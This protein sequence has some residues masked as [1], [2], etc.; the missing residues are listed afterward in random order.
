MA[1]GGRLRDNLAGYAPELKQLQA[2]AFDVGMWDD[3][4]EADETPGAS[5][6]KS[7]VD[8]I[9]YADDEDEDDYG[10]DEM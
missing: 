4:D 7:K 10:K 6:P 5:K 3:E 8:S 9:D 2:T 1:D